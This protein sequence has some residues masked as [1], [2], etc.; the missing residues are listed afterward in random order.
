M[1]TTFTIGE[2]EQENLD[3]ILS[4]L[5]TIYGDYDE[6]K[7][8]YHFTHSGIGIKTKISLV[9]YKDKIKMFKIDKDITDYDSW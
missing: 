4:A 3:N 5:L 6:L 8:T 9:G 1:K 2:K 7:R